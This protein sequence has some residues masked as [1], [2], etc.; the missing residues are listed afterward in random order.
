MN[1]SVT[2]KRR[3]LSILDLIPGA[4]AVQLCKVFSAT[5]RGTPLESALVA[6][7]SVLL[8]AAAMTIVVVAGKG[9]LGGG[10]VSKRKDG[11]AH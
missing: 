5:Y 8:G 4:A 6:G 11:A 7:L 2:K 10:R 3:S 9:A 1:T